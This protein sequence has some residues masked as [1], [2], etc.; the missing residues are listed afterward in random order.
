MSKI[1][2]IAMKDLQLLKRD[3]T[4][5]G[6]IIGVPIL[7][8]VFFGS[9]YGDDDEPDVIEI[10]TVDLD[11]TPASAAF[12]E[13]LAADEALAVTELDLEEADEAVRR[14]DYSARLVIYPGFEEN[15]A[16]FLFGEVP[17][18]GLGVDPSRRAE[19]GILEGLITRRAIENITQMMTEPDAVIPV[20][21]RLRDELEQSDE[22]GTLER[23]VFGRFLG[24]LQTFITEMSSQEET[25][26]EE[27]EGFAFN[28]V[29]ITTAEIRGESN[30]PSTP[31]DISFPQGIVWGLLSVVMAF[32]TSLVNERTLG[33]LVRLRMAPLSVASILAGKALACFVTS[34]FV[35]V[36]LLMLGT[37]VFGITPTSWVLLLVGLICVSVAMTGLMML[38]STF[39]KTERTTGNIGWSLMMVM[40]MLGGGMLPLFMMPDWMATASHLSPIK[41]SVLAIEGGLWRGFSAAE[42]LVPCITLVAI[43]IASFVAGVKMFRVWE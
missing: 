2:A 40:A 1:L 20:L 33:T 42:M 34:T 21:D 25:G 6:F 30:G 37:F 39:G 11:Q 28:P 9:M 8:A 31:Y 36:L 3:R 14:G 13:A 43:G 38:M 5:L 29:N 18:L 24:E 32:A 41:W 4:G 27:E 10:A 26:D 35:M 19:A 16:G 7:F 22:V 15:R 12:I 17:E 23:M